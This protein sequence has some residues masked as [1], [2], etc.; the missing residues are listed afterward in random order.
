M[1]VGYPLLRGRGMG[2]GRGR[3]SQNCP[4]RQAGPGG[5]L[6]KAQ[7]SSGCALDACLT[8]RMRGLACRVR[9]RTGQGKPLSVRFAHS[10]GFSGMVYPTCRSGRLKIPERPLRRDFIAQRG[11][12]PR[13]AKPRGIFPPRA[14][15]RRR[16]A[17]GAGNMVYWGQLTARREWAAGCPPRMRKQQRRQMKQLGKASLKKHYA[18]FVMACLIA[19]FLGGGV[20]RVADLLPGP[21]PTRTPP[22]RLRTTGTAT[23]P[24]W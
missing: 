22:S 6:C 18:I 24:T 5:E 11:H 15:T 1:P 23:A 20:R 13:R 4:T 8:A 12:A 17:A 2:G 21:R 16:V 19:A 14:A 7:L 9:G 3:A 10:P